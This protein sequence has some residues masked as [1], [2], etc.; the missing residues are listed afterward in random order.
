MTGGS[1]LDQGELLHVFGAQA[2]LLASTVESA[3]QVALESFV[4]GCPGLTM[5]ETARHV[6]SSYRMV[7]HWLR[8]G[9]RPNEWRRDPMGGQTLPEYVRAG[10]ATLLAELAGHDAA[11]PCSTWWPANQTY[12]FWRRRM[13]H[14]TIVHRADVQGAAHLQPDPMA[15]DVVLDGIDEVLT[16]WFVY[17]LSV[18]GVVGTRRHLV[19][20]RTGGQEWLAYAGPLGT[21][22]DPVDSEPDAVV[23]GSPM[24]VYLWLWGRVP[25]RLIEIDGNQDA[26]AQLWAL[27]RLATR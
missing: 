13:A 6:G 16:L 4:P 27:L 15:D 18:L 5:E 14:E 21:S 9:R 3:D 20:V 10:S 25:D 24:S 11:E 23:S 1:H 8:E 2:E 17:R 22:I 12:G 7:W 19:S 26:I